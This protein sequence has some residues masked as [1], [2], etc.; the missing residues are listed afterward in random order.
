[1]NRQEFMEKVKSTGSVLGLERME[2]LCAVMGNLQNQIPMIHVAGTNGKGSVCAM[3]EA[4][5]IACGL[6]VGKYSSPSVFSYEEIIQINGQP[7]KQERLDS[8]F[9]EVFL[10][11][12]ALYE[13]DVPTLF[14]LETTAAFCYFYQ[15]NCQIA[16]IETGLGGRLDATNVIASPLLSVITSISMDHC[17]IL[18]DTLA[19]IAF[20]KAGIIKKSGTVVSNRQQDEIMKVLSTEAQKQSASLLIAECNHLVILND[21]IDGIWFD[22]K[23]GER[24]LKNQKLSLAGMAQEENLCLLLEVY[25]QLKENFLLDDETFFQALSRVN[26]PGRFQKIG[27]H[28]IVLIDGA[29]NPD[30]AEKLRD[31]LL[32]F[33]PDRKIRF[34][35]GVFKDKNYQEE[36]KLLL[37]LAQKVYTIKP[38]QSRGLDANELKEVA[39]QYC[40]DV[41]NCGCAAN[42][43]Q[44]A[45]KDA[46]G[47]DCIVVCGSLSILEETQRALQQAKSIE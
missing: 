33:F 35:I 44:Q 27:D 10:K 47:E 16:I 42:G 17:Q 46:D 14:E 12:T 30:A 8:I 38:N 28:P 2:K 22:C 23:I 43:I 25:E 37:P 34:V 32:K 5:L 13:E 36:L 26:H 9:E 18:G 3:L 4:G 39:L 24:W 6:K 1:M 15:E 31:T 11:W 40:Q 19:E 20:H 41:E 29:H 21:T 7:I 45:Y